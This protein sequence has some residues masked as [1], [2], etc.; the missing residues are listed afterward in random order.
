MKV[1]TVKPG[2]PDDSI[3]DGRDDRHD[4]DDLKY[5]LEILTVKTNRLLVVRKTVADLADGH[6]Q[7]TKMCQRLAL[8]YASRQAAVED[9]NRLTSLLKVKF[10]DHA[11]A[12]VFVEKVCQGITKLIEE[13]DSRLVHLSKTMLVG[14][15]KDLMDESFSTM[16]D[17]QAE[18]RTIFTRDCF[19]DTLLKYIKDRPESEQRPDHPECQ[20]SVIERYRTVTLK[21]KTNGVMYSLLKDR[22]AKF[23]RNFRTSLDIEALQSIPVALL[24]NTDGDTLGNYSF[25]GDPKTQISDR[26]R[27]KAFQAVSSSTNVLGSQNKN[28]MSEVIDPGH[29]KD[30]DEASKEEFFP[31]NIRLLKAY[32]TDNEVTFFARLS[33]LMLYQI[34]AKTNAAIELYS[35]EE[36][37][38]FGVNEYLKV[39]SLPA[40]QRIMSHQ[41]HIKR[42]VIERLSSLFYSIGKAVL[43]RTSAD[44][45]IGM[46]NIVSKLFVIENRLREAFPDNDDLRSFYCMKIDS[47][48]AFTLKRFIVTIREKSSYFYELYIKDHLENF[49][50]LDIFN[51][52]L[53]DQLSANL[54]AKIEDGSFY[55][56][57]NQE[58]RDGKFFQ[59]N[60]VKQHYMVPFHFILQRV[61]RHSKGAIIWSTKAALYELLTC[62]MRRRKFINFLGYFS[63]LLNLD[64]FLQELLVPFDSKFKTHLGSLGELRFLKHFFFKLVIGE[65]QQQSTKKPSSVHAAN[66]KVKISPDIGDKTEGFTY[67]HFIETKADRLDMPSTFDAD[68]FHELISLN[69]FVG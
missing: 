44:N 2:D 45:E 46:Y 34:E 31:T 43:G 14:S 67:Q 69:T 68:L 16:V 4:P 26:A 41:P 9:L 12:K 10:D 63:L 40:S 42:L 1:A 55:R 11:E 54:D 27:P 60:T 39:L 53:N 17:I 20:S 25:L 57:F 30:K 3:V 61:D 64:A 62:L 8:A 7:L 48:F 65:G 19:I 29:Q 23:V 18:H 56:L 5:W 32:N 24:S 28:N 35:L 47:F 49:G 58:T 33:N 59:G 38:N 6:D 66:R 50:R 21:L 36:V 37:L 51:R 52:D 13:I 15:I 22:M